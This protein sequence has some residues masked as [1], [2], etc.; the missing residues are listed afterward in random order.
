[1]NILKKLASL[2]RNFPMKSIFITVLVVVLLAVGVQ[3]VFMATGNNT[4]VKSNSGVYRD[5]KILEEEF[6]GESVI[7]LYE[8]DHLLTPDHLEHMK[9]I[10]NTLQTTDS[11]YSIISPVT[12]VEEIANKQSDTFKEGILEIIDGLDTMGS[13]LID[14]GTELNNNAQNNQDIE[15]PGQ[16]ELRLPNLGE[17]DLPEFG[18]IELPKF[19]GT[20]LP[21]FGEMEFPDN[22]GQIEELNKGFSNLI[23]AQQNLGEGTK[24]L[25]DEYVRFGEEIQQIAENL[26]VLAEQI[27]DNPQQAER[28]NEISQGLILLSG[29]MGQITE[30][31][32]QL[33]GISVQTIE[34]LQSI[35][36]KLNEQ[37][38]QQEFMQE[39]QK[40]MQQQ[41]K[42]KMQQEQEEKEAQMK[43]KVQDQ[44]Q[45]KQEVMKT[46]M[47]KQQEQKQEQMKEQVLAQQADKEKQMQEL[48]KEMQGKQ[49][50]QAEKFR[51]LGEGLVEMGGNLQTISEN[52]ETIYDYS[53]IMAPGL[54]KK[55]ATLDQMIYNEGELR[56]M[57]E[58]VIVDDHHMLM[59]IRFKGNVDDTE[60]SEVV[61]TINTYL[62]AEQKDSLKTM[63]SGKPVLDHAIQSSMKE[64]IQKMMGLALFI[65]VVV[66]FFVF[67][68]RWRLLPLVT[69]LVAVIGTIGLMGWLQIPITMVSMAVF[70]ILIG[71][72]ID[73]AIQ[74]QNRYAE[75]MAKED[76]NE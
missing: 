10:E 31:T 1:M 41:M 18:G 44:Q 71:L 22:E 74:F 42:E 21:E 19:E 55:Q 62:D 59:M 28:L 45:A 70:P 35:Q 33:P 76:L 12:L 39:E 58:E 53:D 3:N 67:K 32:S 64:S 29:Q 52:M 50:E 8:S 2:L 4:L 23:S 15:F 56:P 46:Q 9:G 7:V 40:K 51:T 36:Q 54:P 26:S 20:R 49:E 43:K 6:G 72:G 17:T 75:E 16:E 47:Q 24:N 37:K 34:G 60:K 63:V 73:Y 11:I 38:K 48:Q 61:E 69:V 14:I 5:N 30:E 27:E 68:V 57:F 66:L 13:N 25:V 65:M